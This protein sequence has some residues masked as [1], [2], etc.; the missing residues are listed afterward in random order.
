MTCAVS[1]S[2]CFGPLIP[3]GVVACGADGGCPSSLS[4]AQDGLCYRNPGLISPGGAIC[5]AVNPAVDCTIPDTHGRIQDAIDDSA[6]SSIKLN[7]G[8]FNE[9]LVVDRDVIIEGEC[10][11]LDGGGVGT[12]LTI[13]SGTVVVRRMAIRGGQALQGGG[14]FNP[15]GIA[16]EG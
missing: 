16:K 11:T 12:T 7:T 4:C 13:N 10:S 3:D 5:Q 9:R 8:V 15:G 2:S 1:V 14:V 6:C